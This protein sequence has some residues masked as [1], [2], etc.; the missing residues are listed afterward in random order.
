MNRPTKL[1]GT[2]GVRGVANTE[3][4]TAETALK[5]GRA[6][7]HVFKRDD[8]RR[9]RIVIGKDTRL[10]GYMLENA[11]VA[12]ICS[13][14]VDAL[15]LGPLP[16]PAVAF[17]TRSLRAD[18]GV[19]LSASHNPY[20]DNGIKFFSNDGYKLPDELEGQMEAYIASGELDDI[21]PTAAEVG[22]AYR[23][24]DALG[25][26]IEFIKNSLPK[27]MTLDGLKVV[28]DVA[29]GA[30]YKVAPRIFAELGATVFVYSDKPDGMNIN[31]H[32]G[33]LY[34]EVVRKGVIDH[35]ADV[36]ISLDGDGD[37]CI[38]ADDDATVIDGDHVLAIAALDLKA[39]GQLAKDA[40]AAT[41]MSNLG[42]FRAMDDAGIAVHRTKVG[43]RYVLDTMRKEGLNLGGEQSGHVIFSDY[44]TTGDGLITALQILRVM[45]ESGRKLSDL[46]RVLRR[47]PQAL[48]NVT[49]RDKP[50][51][52]S[53][54]GVRTAIGRAEQ[55]LGNE[56]RVLV[57]YSGTEY[58][59][60]VMVEGRE[61]REVKAHAASIAE[62]VRTALG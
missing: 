3:P 60:R 42:L 48:V 18:A 21:R 56:G 41:V 45:R 10:S 39:K 6:A 57:R 52:D 17:I 27:G 12:G 24:D 51:I 40:I 4:M 2:D 47:Y 1:F 59:A 32:C 30:P 38:M 11:L 37:R 49:V 29:N 28:L 20:M 22:K 53:L 13:M 33:A 7:A 23:I 9:H 34:P 14:G 5:L 43:D 50:P 8:S 58:V 25:R 54:D 15:L 36:G 46:R 62:A 31:D 16:T 19:M 44:T 35:R 26:Y 61:E 55:A